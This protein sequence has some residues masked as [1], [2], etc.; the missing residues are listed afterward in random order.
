[1]QL[2]QVQTNQKMAQPASENLDQGL[3]DSGFKKEANDEYYYRI[4]NGRTEKRWVD[5]DHSKSSNDSQWE[6]HR[7]GNQY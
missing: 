2:K 7:Q 6:K 4:E 1:M 5:N 3:R